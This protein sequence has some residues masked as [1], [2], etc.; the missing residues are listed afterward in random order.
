MRSKVTLM[1]AALILA[2][3]AIQAEDQK[4]GKS[5]A[6]DVICKRMQ[7][8]G[9]HRKEKICMTREAWAETRKRS[10]RAMNQMRQRQSHQGGGGET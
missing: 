2:G 10:R 8:T 4:K 5:E 7:V 1:A 3:V 9:T 6:D